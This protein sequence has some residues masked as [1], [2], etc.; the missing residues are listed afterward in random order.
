[1]FNI[2]NDQLNAIKQALDLLNVNLFDNLS[3]AQLNTLLDAFEAFNT[4]FHDQKIEGDKL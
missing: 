2:T 4:V 1:M 3:P